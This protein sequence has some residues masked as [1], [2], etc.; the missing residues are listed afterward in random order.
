MKHYFSSNVEPSKQLIDRLI[1]TCTA[2]GSTVDKI[3]IKY[4]WVKTFG[5]DLTVKIWT[6]KEQ[7]K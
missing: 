4:V 1:E 7:G 3:K 5:N 6:K 2:D